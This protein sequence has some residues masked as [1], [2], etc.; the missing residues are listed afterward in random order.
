M[1]PFQKFNALKIETAQLVLSLEDEAVLEK[2]RALL[3][4]CP[5][6]QQDLGGID[7]GLAELKA[8]KVISSE[9]FLKEIAEL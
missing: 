3:L 9:A 7:R 8:G 2:V 1:N 4:D 5:T 6:S